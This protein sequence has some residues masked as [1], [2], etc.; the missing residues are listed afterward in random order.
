MNDSSSIEKTYSSIEKTYSY[1]IKID[2]DYK[3]IYNCNINNDNIIIYLQ[4]LYSFNEIIV[5]NLCNNPLLK[6]LVQECSKYGFL[7]NKDFDLYSFC[8]NIN[9]FNNFIKDNFFTLC[10]QVKQVEQD[11]RLFLDCNI[12]IYYNNYFND[13]IIT[14]L[15]RPDIFNELT[16]IYNGY[17]DKEQINELIKLDKEQI[18]ELIKL[19]DNL[20]SNIEIAKY[21]INKIINKNIINTKISIFEIKELIHKY[22]YIDNNQ[23]NKIKFS[24]IWL[25]LLSKQNINED[26]KTYIKKQLPKALEE[27][28]LSKKR[29]TSGIYWFGI[30]YK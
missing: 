3:I 16:L 8:E 9:Y 23:E 27:M 21:N 10:Y 18:N 7:I 26:Y 25:L 17:C 30:I 28:G 6:Y 24:D 20:F 1:I 13:I 11:I 4:K 5:C 15:E 29:L 19:Q 12:Y 14:N 2:D 22:F